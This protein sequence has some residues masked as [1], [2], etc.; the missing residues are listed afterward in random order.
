MD[1][2][3]VKGEEVL[4]KTAEW[5]GEVAR[6]ALGHEAS[7]YTQDNDDTVSGP[8]GQTA[9]ACTQPGLSWQRGSTILF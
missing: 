6:L 1:E 5:L 7:I 2:D 4:L 3:L 9:A 8:A